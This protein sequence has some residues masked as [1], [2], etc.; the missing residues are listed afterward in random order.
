MLFKTLVIGTILCLTGTALAADP[1][2]VVSDAA[3][4]LADTANY[5]WRANTYDAADAI[6][7]IQD[8]QTERD[9]DTLIKLN[10]GGSYVQV[11]LRGDSAVMN[12]GD[13]WQRSDEVA[14]RQ[15]TRFM[16]A[17]MSPALVAAQIASR[18]D[19][20]KP[21]GNEFVVQISG[22]EVNELMRPLYSLNAIRSRSVNETGAKA[23]V[24]FWITDGLLTKFQIHV[25]G[26][27]SRGGTNTV[28]DRTVTVDFRDIGSTRVSLPDQAK[29]KLG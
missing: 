22:G 11:A 27:I 2:E 17:V 9:G 12:V 13:G 21:E 10:T 3:K 1:V 26:T 4:K 8:G 7:V 16:S 29:K 25:T 6:T 23:T 19:D 15:A 28:V 24:K 14:D 5:T 18:L 20:L